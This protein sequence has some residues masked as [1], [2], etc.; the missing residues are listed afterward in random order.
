MSNRYTILFGFPNDNGAAIAPSLSARGINLLRSEPTKLRIIA[1]PEAHQ[2]GYAEYKGKLGLFLHSYYVKKAISSARVGAS[3][4]SIRTS[5]LHFSPALPPINLSWNV[6]IAEEVLESLR[7]NL[8]GTDSFTMRRPGLIV[9]PTFDNLPTIRETRPDATSPCPI[10]VTN[11]NALPTAV[12]LLRLV[13]LF[14]AMHQY[15]AF[16]DEEHFN[17]LLEDTE[18]KGKSVAGPSD[19]VEMSEVFLCWFVA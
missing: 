12:Y 14:L 6:P 8:G 1:S 19:D 2:K 9:D 15:P 10:G 13:N 17:N 16:V 7:K 11:L 18:K 3:L 5:D 4:P